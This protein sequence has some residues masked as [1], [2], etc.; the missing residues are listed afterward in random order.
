MEN[1][2]LIQNYINQKLSEQ[3]VQDFEERLS[4]D[5]SFATQVQDYRNVQ[6]AIKENERTNLKAMLQDLEV[7]EGDRQ[8][9]PVSFTKKYRHIYAAAAIIIFSIIGFQFLEQGPT[10]QDLYAS[11]S[12]PYPNTLKPITR[13]EETT[14]ELSK[15]LQAYEAEDYK[16]ASTRLDRVLQSN[17]NPDILFYKAMSLYNDGKQQ[18]AT[19]ALNMLKNKNTNY[20]PQV[21]WYSA[22]LALKNDNTQLA[23]EQLDS[24]SMLNSGYKDAAVKRIKKELKD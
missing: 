7:Q 10:N 1:D 23:R 21:Y 19:A 22:L 14:D 5:P 9:E 3:E 12:Q 4:S 2:Q 11:F 17:P 24:L 20:T 13:G 6:N 18:E 16:S 8:E 15:A